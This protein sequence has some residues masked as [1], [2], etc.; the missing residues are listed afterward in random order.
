MLAK[1]GSLGANT[2]STKSEWPESECAC[3]ELLKPKDEHE[4]EKHAEDFIK[5]WHLKPSIQ[6]A[7]PSQ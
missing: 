6:N 4:S 3:I 2:C 1:C 5:I 7:P